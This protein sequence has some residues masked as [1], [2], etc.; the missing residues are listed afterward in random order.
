MNILLFGGSSSER[1]VSVASA[2]F[3]SKHIDAQIWFW[4]KEGFIHEVDYTELQNAK[5]T[6]TKEFIPTKPMS[7]TNIEEAI[8]NNTQAV[9]ILAL[10]GGEGENGELQKIFEK[11]QVAFTGSD[12][13]S[14]HNA[15][16]KLIAKD[17]IK[18]SDI[19][20]APH[21][22]LSNFNMQEQIEKFYNTHKDC[23]IK[24]VSDGSSSDCFKITNLKDIPIIL[25]KLPQKDYMIE[26]L[27]YGKELTV[28]VIDDTKEIMPLSPT[29]VVLESDRD[30]DYD[31]KYL[32]KGS[33]EITPANISPI[34]TKQAQNLACTAHKLLNL[35]G[36]S[37]SD[38]ISTKEGI[39][40]LEINTLPGLTTS[41]FMPQQLNYAGIPMKDFLNT[42]IS[43]ALLRQKKLYKNN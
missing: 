6:F 32:M 3:M 43:L 23:I 31:A 20:L 10:H 8:R 36:Y 38:M 26:K 42:Q 14:S 13:L 15:F 7:Y 9:F 17:L 4:H 28:A 22:E 5:D 24:P 25:K 35:Y 39:Y 21:Q 41:S 40:F 34:L 19:L 1:L 33:K 16:N 30:F 11:Y 18:N 27:I 2:Q 29:E 37:R 12:S